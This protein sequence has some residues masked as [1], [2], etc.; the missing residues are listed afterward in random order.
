MRL[1][2]IS[3]GSGIGVALALFALVVATGQTFG[4]RCAKLFP[5]GDAATIEQCVKNF[6]AR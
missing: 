1:F 6:V 3:V 5:N 2:L 4:Q